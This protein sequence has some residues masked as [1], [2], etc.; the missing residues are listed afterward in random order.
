MFFLLKPLLL[1]ISFQKTCK[2]G[3]TGNVAKAAG[4]CLAHDGLTGTSS[5]R[6]GWARTDPPPPAG[7]CQPL[8]RTGFSSAVWAPILS[9]VLAEQACPWWLGRP[10]LPGGVLVLSRKDASVPHEER[11]CPRHRGPACPQRRL[12]VSTRRKMR[13]VPSWRNHPSSTAYSGEGEERFP[14]E[15]C[16]QDTLADASGCATMQRSDGFR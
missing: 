6:E 4:P 12:A 15:D 7:H 5:T 14:P 2:Q 11:S 10:V 3:R 13:L 16:R 9:S 8:A 1:L